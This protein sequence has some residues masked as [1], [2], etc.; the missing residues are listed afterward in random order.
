MFGVEWKA[1]VL[2]TCSWFTCSRMDLK[3]VLLEYVP[4]VVDDLERA[5]H[6]GG[7][8]SSAT[9]AARS[10]NLGLLVSVLS[11]AH[12]PDLRHGVVS[13]LVSA[14]STPFAAFVADPD[15]AELRTTI[16]RMIFVCFRSVI[17]TRLLS[18]TG[19]SVTSTRIF[20]VV[21]GL[22]DVR[23]LGASVS[24]GESWAVDGLRQRFHALV[25]SGVDRVVGVLSEARS[26]WRS[27]WMSVSA[28]A[29]STS[30]PEDEQRIVGGGALAMVHCL[31]WCD[32]N[33]YG[34]LLPASWFVGEMRSLGLTSSLPLGKL[35]FRTVTDTD[36][37]RLIRL[38]VAAP[39]LPG[40]KLLVPAD[41]R[42]VGT[43]RVA[44]R[45]RVVSM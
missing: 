32:G 44:C 9:P 22:G 1:G 21:A 16:R 11:G 30:S 38:L 5:S 14:M 7:G 10:S 26:V 19:N 13:A 12:V 8:G 33:V 45:E 42:I 34:L 6:C 41:R 40:I 31:V 25:G 2:Y 3:S 24:L 23:D 35:E 39:I 17:H 28:S 15:S 37:D 43:C 20:N 29:R 4:G 36:L 27:E 18:V